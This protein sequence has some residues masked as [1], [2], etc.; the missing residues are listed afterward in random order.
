MHHF[1][2][3]RFDSRIAGD[4]M[5]SRQGGYPLSKAV[6]RCEAA[7]KPLGR[8]IVVPAADVVTWSRQ[9]GQLAVR[10]KHRVGAQVEQKTLRQ[11]K[12][13]ALQPLQLHCAERQLRKCSS[14][15]LIVF[16]SLHV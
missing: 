11:V 7:S 8:E 10:L 2:E 4:G 6:S 16:R 12:L 9:S 13:L 14:R 5:A 3:L 15:S 1:S